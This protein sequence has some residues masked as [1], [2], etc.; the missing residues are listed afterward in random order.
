MT[1]KTHRIKLTAFIQ[2]LDEVKEGMLA[3]DENTI[4]TV[5]VP[6]L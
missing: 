4:R 6:F 2:P 1:I 5:A 3:A